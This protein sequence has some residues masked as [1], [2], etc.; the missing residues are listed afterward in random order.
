[1][2]HVAQNGDIVMP[3]V[4]IATR[5]Y[6]REPAYPLWAHAGA[7]PTAGAGEGVPPFEPCQRRKA[8]RQ[9]TP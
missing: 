2:A 9:V 5:R 3:R 6:L 7:V 4:A 1:M 8:G